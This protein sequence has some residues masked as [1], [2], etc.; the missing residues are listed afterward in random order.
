VNGSRLGAIAGALYVAAVFAFIFLPILVL[1]VFSFQDGRLPVPPLRGLTLHW[2]E[3]LFA[4]ERM[5]SALA[6]SVLVGVV[7]AGA[8]TLLG[9]LAAYGLARYRPRAR[10]ALEGLIMAPIA[11]SYLVI[12]LGLAI[13]FKQLGLS[14]SLEQV[15]VGHIVI[16]L[17]IA[18]AVILSQM[19]EHQEH[20]ER[21]AR[22][23]GASEL[24]VLTG[25]TAP[26]LLPGLLAAF[27]LTFTLS[28][29]EFVIALMLS[30]FEVTLPVEIWSAIR[31][32]LDPQTNAV[33]T[34]VFV[35]SVGL[36]LIAYPL[37]TWLSR[38]AR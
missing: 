4:D 36:L 10:R 18:F 1:V 14:R 2:Y 11:V 32:G 16:N 25:I 15:V 7:A 22:D 6:N 23:L 21:A 19:D 13:A 9:F 27:L 37:F 20:A 3:S 12:G 28:W 5:M 38:R 17:P 31:T 33:G 35:L 34:F 30:R 8:A 24:R 29:D 26:L